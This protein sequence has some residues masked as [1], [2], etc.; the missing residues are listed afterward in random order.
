MPGGRVDQTTAPGASRNHEQRITKIENSDG[1]FPWIS[2]G[3]PGGPFV[4][5]D[6]PDFQ[7]GWGPVSSFSPPRFKRVLNW[8]FIEGGAGITGGA[9][10]TVVFTL[11]ARDWPKRAYELSAAVAGGGSF[12]YVV[13]TD[14]TVV[15]VTQCGCG[16]GGVGPTG[17][18]GATG[19]AGPTGP[20]GDAGPTGATGAT[21]TTGSPG[22]TGPTGATGTAGATGATG[23]T[24]GA[25]V[26]GPTGPTGSAG[27]TGPTG[28]TGATGADSTVPGPT[29]ATGATGTAGATGATGATGTGVTGPTGA[30]GT[31]GTAGAT[32]ATGATG[33]GAT[34]PTGPTGATGATGPTAQTVRAQVPLDTPDASGNGYPGLSTN[35]GFTNVRRIW[36]Y[37]T[38]LVDGTWEGSIHIPHNYAS[39]GAI[40]L[41]GVANAT[42]G[43]VRLQVSTSVVANGSTENPAYTPE[44]AV[45]HTVV[46]TANALDDVTFTLS[47]TPVADSTLNVKVAR[48]GTNGGDT[49]A[50]D[51]GLVECIFSYTS[52]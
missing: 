20:T 18:T 33:T 44:T 4:T 34:G 2:V 6:S 12:N 38:K 32:G 9:D 43:A 28:A 35:N 29:G 15:Y 16:T 39:A 17:P 46:G 19:D 40:I 22:A 23:A 21:G 8:L 36:P 7:N 25:G 42:T 41:R 37:F 30:T 45:N 24:G 10:N 47:T 27:V 11:P 13:N 49:L 1:S 51:Y 3:A 52:A 14:G 31:A 26:T 5:P 48:I 50:V